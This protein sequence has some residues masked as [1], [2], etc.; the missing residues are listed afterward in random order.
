MHFYLFLLFVS[1]IIFSNSQCIQG[2]NHCI[3]CNPIT[4]LCYECENN[5]YSP[6]EEGGC[7]KNSKCKEYN[8][9]CIECEPG[10]NLCKICEKDYFPDENGQCS[11]TNNCEISEFGK[12]LKCKENYILIGKNTDYSLKI[13]KPIIS[14]DLKNCEKINNINGLCEKCKEGYFLNEGDKKCSKIE[15]CYESIFGTCKKCKK[16]YYLDKKEDKCKEQNEIFENCLESINGISCDKCEE[17]YFFDEEGNCLF[18]NFCSK[19]GKKNS[20]EKCIEGYHL[21]QYGG[22][23]LSTINC[24]SGI[25]SIDVCNIC[26][27]KYYLDYKD[28]KCKSN[29]ENNDFKYCEYADGFCTQCLAGYYIGKDNKCSFTQNCAYSENLTC[30]ECIDN[31]YLGFDNYCTNVE[32]CIYSDHYECVECKDNYYYDIEKGICIKAENN[33][34]NCKKTY[35]GEYCD[36]GKYNYYLNITV[37]LFYSNLEPNNFYKCAYTNIFGYCDNCERNYYLGDKDHKC[38]KIPSCVI[39]ENEDKC[40][41]CRD[42]C[43]LDLKKQKCEYNYEIKNETEKFYY[44]CKQTNEEGT[45]CEICIDNYTLDENGICTDNEHCIEK[46]ENGECLKCLNNEEESYCL[47][48]IFGC[49]EL[50]YDNCLE[51]NNIYKIKSCTKC[52]DGYEIDYYNECSEIESDN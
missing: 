20:C 13:C 5:I 27:E 40:L 41:E 46:N 35:D 38:S 21:S 1:E 48:N 44:R 50:Y 43:C 22:S 37:Y 12:C 28:G 10:N 39:S 49:V 9:H 16:Y 42:N 45:Q 23:C 36:S 3:K 52:N 33:F 25:G 7:R 24:Q 2:F 15:N 17:D 47:N 29:Q 26:K 34:R 4:D 11:Y 32:N 30:L 51:C 14:S 6:D 8:N 18:T 19:K 31:Y